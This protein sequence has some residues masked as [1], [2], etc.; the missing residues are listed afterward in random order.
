MNYSFNRDIRYTF[1][2]R[3][4]KPVNSAIITE[5]WI[6][7][8]NIGNFKT[9]L[10]EMDLSLPF[11]GKNIDNFEEEM[12]NQKELNQWNESGLNE[13]LGKHLN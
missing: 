12:K 10:L 11:R 8:K 2:K 9:F 7:E 3:C 5:D 4:T 13:L 6:K 1:L